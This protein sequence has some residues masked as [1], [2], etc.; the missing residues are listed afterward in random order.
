MENENFIRVG[1]TLYKIVK[2]ACF[3]KAKHIFVCKEKLFEFVNSFLYGLFHIFLFV[4]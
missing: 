1:T 4:R 3:I 2:L